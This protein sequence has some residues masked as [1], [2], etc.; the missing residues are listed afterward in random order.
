[1]VLL[2]IILAA[3]VLT[4]CTSHMTS[5]DTEIE[6]SPLIFTGKVIA[7]S[8]RAAVV[9]VD[10]VYK[11]DRS[12]DTVKIFLGTI[13]GC[14]PTPYIFHCV[15]KDSNYLFIMTQMYNKK[16]GEIYTSNSKISQKCAAPYLE[17][18]ERARMYRTESIREIYSRVDSARVRT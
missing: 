18:I 10:S 6:T 2:S 14:S 7:V 11:G 1:M 9:L 16:S 15:E 8:K 4:A 12:C 17:R 5:I 13:P 3:E